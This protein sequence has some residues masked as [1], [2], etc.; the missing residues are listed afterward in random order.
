MSK[1]RI[2]GDTSGYVDIAVPA[3]AGTR[4]LN[5]DKVPQTDTS[6]NTGIGTD[7]PFTRA[8]VGD[9]TG[10]EVLT[11]FSG[12]TGEG[13]L[14]FADAS[15]G[16]GAYQG[17]VEYDHNAGKLN[18]GAGGTTPV[19]IDS[20]GNVGIGHNSPSY[21]LDI[22]GTGDTVQ[23]IANSNP[24]GQNGRTLL[25][26]DD[27]ASVSQDSFISYAATSSPGHDAYWGKRTTSGEGFF[28]V[29]SSSGG[30]GEALTID[31]GSGYVGLGQTSPGYALDINGDNFV[32]SSIRLTR[33][34]SGQDND[35]GIYFVNNAGAN[36]DWGMGG[37]WFTNSSD[38]GNA[39]GMI[40]C[41]TDDA[42]GTSGK[43]EF[44]TGTSAVGNTTDPSMTIDS[45]SR[46]ILKSGSPIKWG[47]AAS[48]GYIY[49]TNNS[50]TVIGSYDDLYL[51]SNW[52]RYF[53]ASN[54]HPGT[55]EFAR[56]SHDANWFTGNTGIGTNGPQQLLHING[57][58]PT[59]RL[60]STDNNQQG[61]EFYQSG[62][63][64]ASIMW[65]QGNANLEIKNFRNDQNASNLYANIDFFT[66]GSTATSPNYTPNLVM[67]ITDDGYV[68]I[69]EADPDYILDIKEENTPTIRLNDG[70][71]YQA[72]ISLAGNDLE[73]RG[74]GGRTEIYNGSNDGMSSTKVMV[75]EN[76]QRV[77]IG[78]ELTNNSVT[79]NKLHV[80]DATGVWQDEINASAAVLRLETNAGT[81]GANKFGSGIVFNGLGGH[82]T[83]HGD[84]IH[85]WIGLKYY[86]T[87]GH[88]RTWLV[89]GTNNTYSGE[90]QHDAGCEPRLMIDPMGRHAIS[91]DPTGY[92]MGSPQNTLNV[93]GGARAA[94]G[95]TSTGGGIRITNSYVE[96]N[97]YGNGAALPK[98]A[99]LIPI[100]EQTVQNGTSEGWANIGWANCARSGE[101]M[102]RNTGYT[103]AGR[104][105]QLGFYIEAG[106][107]EAG[108]I[109]L[110]EDSFQCYGSSDNGT[111]FRIID[112]DS[113]VVIM[114]MLQSSW[115]MNVRGNVNSN[116]SSF[117]GISDQRL[118]KS[119]Q[120]VTTP[121]ILTKYSNLD[122]K[123]Y[124]RIDSY[125]YIK[126]KYEDVEELR[127]VGLVAQE[128]EAIFPE[129]VGS[130]PVIDPRGLQSVW[131]EIG[132]ELTE[133]KNIDQTQMLWKTMEAVQE[134]IKENKALK[135]RVQA[136]ES[137]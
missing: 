88:E 118:K 91:T 34:D 77:G 76:N 100:N 86:D 59:I 122:I 47:D 44:V 61:V 9:G 95:P 10:T 29:K 90:A 11:I 37:I 108:G 104:S 22:S 24:S 127:E 121:D 66:G 113:D 19:T 30:A 48:L 81:R 68:G 63:K 119:F 18:L 84:N 36:D 7:T 53:N 39:Y 125:D 70:G 129:A 111:T 60:E 21:K 3:V 69:G 87:P 49:S 43:L 106:R 25:I 96:N 27:Y 114:E 107:G 103:G 50:D 1:V 83:A 99:I 26:R 73:I 126:N 33:T 101:T 135:E 57:S 133:I 4:T 78:T 46:V 5:L 40:R 72:Y 130:T 13:Q 131:D 71:Q 28:A 42:T 98:H 64:N 32:K 80:L 132:E 54:G 112:K 102:H 15:S 14:R 12:A 89:F 16:T 120:D 128:V 35:P 105:T 6:G 124:I 134:L 110:D 51:N 94:T 116:Q 67:R 92:D 75:L 52:V 23:Y 109:C 38:S 85:A 45:A 137:A 79:N 123:S 20:S 8:V 55:T 97:N 117:S 65:G 82:S 58:G 136:L 115:N 17:R 74:S 2:Y 31:L 93:D 41:R 56:I 62:T